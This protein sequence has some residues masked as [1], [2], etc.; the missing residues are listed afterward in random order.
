MLAASLLTFHGGY[1]V[2]T[3]AQRYRKRV[4]F[5]AAKV[6]PYGPKDGRAL[7]PS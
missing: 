5:S 6:K 7:P 2:Q 4:G 3:A 1:L